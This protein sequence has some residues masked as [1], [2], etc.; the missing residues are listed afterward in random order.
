MPNSDDPHKDNYK[1]PWSVT[2]RE[3]GA[4][5]QELKELRHD[6][7]NLRAIVDLSGISSVTKEE[8]IDNRE[9]ITK[10]KQHMMSSGLSSDSQ[11]VLIEKF[12]EELTRLKIKVYTAFSV[13]G[14]LTGVIVWLIDVAFRVLDKVQ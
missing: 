5:E 3:F 4:L 7:R 6:F 11:D 2:D 12:I 9:D 10:F 14:I 8:I 13:I 1:W